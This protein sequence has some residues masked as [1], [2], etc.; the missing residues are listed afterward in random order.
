MVGSRQTPIYGIIAIGVTVLTLLCSPE[1]G[2][3]RPPQDCYP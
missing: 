3:A 1:T 2:V